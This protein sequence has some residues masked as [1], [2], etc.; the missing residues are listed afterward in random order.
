VAGGGADHQQADH[1]ER[2][3]HEQGGVRDAISTPPIFPKLK[4]LLI[5][6]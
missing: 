1:A 4:M 2:D 5:W 3:Q 6:N